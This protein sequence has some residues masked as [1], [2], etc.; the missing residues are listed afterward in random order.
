M[1]DVRFI[2]GFFPK[3]PHAKAP[4][5]VKGAGSIKA[6]DMINFLTAWVAAHPGE[7]WLRYQIKE[8]KAGKLYVVEDTWKPEPRTP[9]EAE[10]SDT[11]KDD[12]IPF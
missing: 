1:S 7:E 9:Q 5:F 2:E 8:S 3:E 4:D 10:T 12:D 11:F 6:Q